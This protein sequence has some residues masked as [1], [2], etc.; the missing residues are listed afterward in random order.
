VLCAS[1]GKMMSMG[2]YFID[3]TSS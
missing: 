3:F 1:R 2:I